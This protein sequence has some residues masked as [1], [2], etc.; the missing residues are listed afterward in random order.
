MAAFGLRGPGT[1]H[2]SSESVGAASLFMRQ[3]CYI[4][5]DLPERWHGEALNAVGTALLG[6]AITGS[7]SW[8]AILKYVGV[9]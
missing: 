1:H 5:R 3:G 2:R 4:H 9:S 7:S 8:L 6:V